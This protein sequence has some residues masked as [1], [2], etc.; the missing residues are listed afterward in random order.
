MSEMQL[1]EGL[2]W[3][4]PMAVIKPVVPSACFVAWQGY[5]LEEMT[6]AMVH[7]GTMPQDVLDRENESVRL[8]LER[9]GK[10]SRSTRKASVACS[11]P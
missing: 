11:C 1:E 8:L 3:R 10:P 2:M 7:Y 6:P 9:N 5:K 4:R